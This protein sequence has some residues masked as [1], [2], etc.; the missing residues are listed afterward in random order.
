MLKKDSELSQTETSSL[1]IISSGPDVLI[2]Q[3][4]SS[5]KMPSIPCSALRGLTTNCLPWVPRSFI[6]QP[7]ESGERTFGD[8]EHPKISTFAITYTLPCIPSFQVNKPSKPAPLFLLHSIQAAMQTP[9]V[10]SPPS[11]DP[12]SHCGDVQSGRTWHGKPGEC[13]CTSTCG[14]QITAGNLVRTVRMESPPQTA[15]VLETHLENVLLE[16]GCE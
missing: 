7:K 12:K 4:T 6:R 10:H 15:I 9:L 2:A 14:T 3:Y 5:T 13:H 11:Q 16:S 1:S 8:W